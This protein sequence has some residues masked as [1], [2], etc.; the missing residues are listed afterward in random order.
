M[1]E[2]LHELAQIALEAKVKHKV[3][4][5]N[6]ALRAHVDIYRKAEADRKRDEV[7][8]VFQER[9]LIRRYIPRWLP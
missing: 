9:N 8:R 7:I 2:M 6:Q 1:N 5:F 3:D 4:I